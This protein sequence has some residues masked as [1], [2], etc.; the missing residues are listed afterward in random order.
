MALK[1]PTKMI[2][3]NKTDSMTFGEIFCLKCLSKIELNFFL[4]YEE[5]LIDSII[6]QEKKFIQSLKVSARGFYFSNQI[7]IRLSKYPHTK[8]TNYNGLLPTIM[9]GC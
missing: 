2:E 7:T 6:I 3:F 1:Y 4:D 9:R 8:S 5:F